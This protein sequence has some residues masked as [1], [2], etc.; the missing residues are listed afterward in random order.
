MIKLF[1]KIQFIMT[2]HS[3]L[4]LLGMRKEF[5]DDGFEILSLP[6]AD[7][8]DAESFEEFT[9][10]FDHY[11]STGRMENWIQ[12]TVDRKF[13]PAVFFEG[14]IDVRYLRRAG[15]LLGRES[16]LDRIELFDGNGHGGLDNIWKRFDTPANVA[17]TRK[18][19][20]VYDPEMTARKD[21]SNGL[22]IRRV[23]PSNE[24]APIKK[25]IENLFS[26]KTID[27]V[28]A[29][30]PQFFD[31]TPPLTK[32]IRGKEANIPEQWEVNK[33]EKSNLCKWLCDNGTSEDFQGF[34]SVLDLIEECLPVDVAEP[35]TLEVG[36]GVVQPN[37]TKKTI[38]DKLGYEILPCADV[39]GVHDELISKALST[40]V[41]LDELDSS[42]NSIDSVVPHNSDHTINDCER[43]PGT[44][45]D[46]ML[47][48]LTKQAMRASTNKN[49]LHRL[50]SK[51]FAQSHIV[52]IDDSP[53]S[54]S[55]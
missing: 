41:T 18:V 14:D 33:D 4:F 26:R 29:Q 32:R 5:G 23:I 31:I 37:V 45:T 52:T 40:F 7:R 35:H 16:L 39:N 50:A 34:M 12:S 48:F 24:L 27:W 44:N 53:G 22:A 3:P 36:A 43:N 13:S 6:S 54:K 8:I 15:E 47:W 28:N 46:T 20:L 51:S 17:M 9:E 2:T 10:V 19:V 38:E 11:S 21:S 25:G 30:N 42:N 49:I 55:T 1:P